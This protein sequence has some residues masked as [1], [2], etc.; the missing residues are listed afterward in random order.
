MSYSGDSS[1]YSKAAKAALSDLADSH[2]SLFKEFVAGQSARGPGGGADTIFNRYM[3]NSYTDKQKA[4]LLQFRDLL[5][6]AMSAGALE[7]DGMYVDDRKSLQKLKNMA[8]QAIVDHSISSVMV[9]KALVSGRMLGANDLAALT[10]LP[11]SS[12]YI[13]S[14]IATEGDGSGR[15]AESLE[16]IK[17]LALE[18]P[19]VASIDAPKG[20]AAEEVYAS[21][22]RDQAQLYA[23]AYDEF[24]ALDKEASELAMK[25]IEVVVAMESLTKDRLHI[26]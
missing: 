17:R 18:A 20:G 14:I 25:A 15:V 3:N 5:T 22:R 8:R 16:L 4:Q 11:A 13:Q 9:N 2:V 19:F 7:G 1:P 12:K 26:Q 21:L 23:R 24:S 6:G 10:Y